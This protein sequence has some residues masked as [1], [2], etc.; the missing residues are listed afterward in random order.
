VTG[1]AIGETVIT[2]M[3]LLTRAVELAAAA[4][5]A[6]NHPFGA[7]LAADD[8]SVIAEAANTVETERDPTGHAELN[9][10]RKTGHLG[11]E[12]L[13]AT[14]LYTSTEPCA[15]CAGGIYWSGIGRV[16]FAM[17]ESE[18]LEMTG[19]DPRNLTLD[20]PSRQV[21]AAGSRLVEV[22]GPVELAAARE[23]VKS[24]KIS[25][26]KASAEPTAMVRLPLLT[27]RRA[28]L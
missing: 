24:T 27:T 17:A 5:A 26:I 12:A 11:S 28:P 16:V 2:T 1:E 6:G 10:V 25:G 14:T 21:F 7:L 22:Q 13:A 8:G 4:R 9:L 19:K 20:L 18:L 3:T 23:D 15:M